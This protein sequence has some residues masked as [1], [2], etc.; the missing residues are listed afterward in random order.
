MRGILYRKSS[1]SYEEHVR[2]E[3]FHGELWIPGEHIL[4]SWAIGG[5]NL[6]VSEVASLSIAD[7]RTWLSE[8]SVPYRVVLAL[9]R[10]LVQ[11]RAREKAVAILLQSAQQNEG[12]V[13]RAL[14]VMNLPGL[15]PPQ[16]L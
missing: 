15:T 12:K 6:Q 7:A 11:Q 5:T 4:V 9:R 2:R 3:T 1:V 10:C 8:I 14:G 16:C 13:R